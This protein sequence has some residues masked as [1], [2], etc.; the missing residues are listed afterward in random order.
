MTTLR[1]HLAWLVGVTRGS[2]SADGAAE[3]DEGMVA[4]SAKGFLA[5]LKAELRA[6]DALKSNRKPGT[7]KGYT[8]DS[9]ESVDSE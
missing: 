8:S 7:K 3:D 5:N 9:C 2:D 4:I 6:S 1:D